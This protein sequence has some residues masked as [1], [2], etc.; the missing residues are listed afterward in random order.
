MNK[1]GLYFLIDALSFVCFV[2]LTSTGVILHF[3]LP[4]GSGRWRV[5]WGMDRHEWG[6]IH[7]WISAIFLLILSVHIFYHWK[8][9]VNVVKGHS[10]EYSGRR[11]V[12][13]II[14]LI[15]VIAL[16][17]APLLSGV[18]EINACLLYTSDAADEE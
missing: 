3:L 7:A 9:I 17:L 18:Q 4:P 10:S 1:K 15:A 12:I 8:W 6:D 11:L 16:A 5:I 14:G 13:G 2:F